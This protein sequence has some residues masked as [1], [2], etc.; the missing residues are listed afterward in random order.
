MY[1]RQAFITR[2][3]ERE[4]DEAWEDFIH[5]HH[6]EVHSDFYSSWIA[7]HPRRTGE[8]YLSQYIDAKYLDNNPIPQTGDFEELW[9]W[10]DRFRPAEEAAASST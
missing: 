7:N 10:F 6:Y 8:A 9:A 2:Q 3:T 5:S 4:I 1:K